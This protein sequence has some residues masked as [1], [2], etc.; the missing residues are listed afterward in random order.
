MIFEAQRLTHIVV[1]AVIIIS[2]TGLALGLG[3]AM[4]LA[5]SAQIFPVGDASSNDD[6]SLA[7]TP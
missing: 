3:W 2:W 6:T 1:L 7:N 4:R 5:N